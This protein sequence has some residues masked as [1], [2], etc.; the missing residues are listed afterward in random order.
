MNPEPGEPGG[1][2]CRHTQTE[3]IRSCSERERSVLLMYKVC[4]HQFLDNTP[5]SSYNSQLASLFQQVAVFLECCS[6]SGD[7]SLVWMALKCVC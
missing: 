6:S 3:H 1:P 2:V 7:E 5:F 4:V